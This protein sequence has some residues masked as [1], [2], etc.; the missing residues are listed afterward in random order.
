MA[1][2][3]PLVAQPEATQRLRQAE[4]PLVGVVRLELGTGAWPEPGAHITARRFIL[5]IGN[6]LE[7]N[8]VCFISPHFFFPR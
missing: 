5:R 2:L 7:V 4:A 8:S 3:R 1:Q 6:E